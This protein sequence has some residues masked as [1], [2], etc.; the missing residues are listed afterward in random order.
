MKIDR[1]TELTQRQLLYLFVP[2]RRFLLD[3]YDRING[4]VLHLR[5]VIAQ[6][7]QEGLTWGLVDVG[8]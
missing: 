5:A 2:L 7:L 3:D 4:D 8:G 1:L 6:R